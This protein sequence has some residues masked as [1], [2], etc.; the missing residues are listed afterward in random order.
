MRMRIR[1]R[2]RMHEQWDAGMLWDAKHLLR[3][4]CICIYA[5][6][7]CMCMRMNMRRVITRECVHVHI[8]AH[9]CTTRV[10]MHRPR[11]SMH[12]GSRTGHARVRARVST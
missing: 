6:T 10:R 12:A 2:M 7:M 4:I 8:P 5:C 3:R 1:E 9:T 11:L